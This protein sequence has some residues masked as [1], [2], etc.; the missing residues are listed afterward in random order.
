M[1]VFPAAVV[2]PRAWSVGEV[3]MSTHVQP[4]VFNLTRAKPVF[5][6]LKAIAAHV[7]TEVQM[8]LIPEKKKS[9][10]TPLFASPPLF[11]RGGRWMG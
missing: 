3:R 7:S 11:G 4:L 9:F 8:W 6:A 1:V 2:V 5:W 10:E